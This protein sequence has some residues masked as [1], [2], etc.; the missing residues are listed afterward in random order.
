MNW[1]SLGI[2]GGFWGLRFRE[3][4]HLMRHLFN[5]PH[6]DPKGELPGAEIPDGEQR[7]A[8]RREAARRMITER[9]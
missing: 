5:M 7:A 8:V 1:A 6:R 2:A 3:M 9:R 4:E